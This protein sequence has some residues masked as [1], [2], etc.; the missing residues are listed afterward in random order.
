M[1][2]YLDMKNLKDI[3]AEGLLDVDDDKTK[4]IDDFFDNPF[5]AIINCGP[6]I[7]A[8]NDWDMY[9]DIFEKSIK[10]KCESSFEYGGVHTYDSKDR[11]SHWL[12]TILEEGPDK[13]K[14]IHMQE[15][16]GPYI[17]DTIVIMSFRNFPEKVRLRMGNSLKTLNIKGQRATSYELSKKQVKMLIDMLDA[18][19]RGEFREWRTSK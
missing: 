18:Y 8:R 15:R 6:K 1:N 12:L 19:A 17:L 10:S 13:R 5:K 7:N 14:L 11:N 16:K 9:L 4:F 3:I 2:D